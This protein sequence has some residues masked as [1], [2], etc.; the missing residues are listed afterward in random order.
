MFDIF[1]TN[2]LLLPLFVILGIS[3]FTLIFS[4]LLLGTK[5]KIQKK[6]EKEE[7][8]LLQQNMQEFQKYKIT[9]FENIDIKLS[10]SGLKYKFHLNIYMFLIASIVSGIVFG[11]IG[12]RFINDFIFTAFSFAGGLILPYVLLDWIAYFQSAKVKKQV[13]SF[14]AIMINNI[15]IVGDIYNAIIK[16]AQQMENPLKQYLEE[17]ELEYQSGVDLYKCFYR[18]K[19]K[20]AD[21]RFARVIDVLLVHYIKGGKPEVTLSSLQREFIAREV[22]EDRKRKQQFA[23]I[24]GIFIVIGLNVFIVSMMGKFMPEFFNELRNTNYKYYLIVGIINIVISL[25]IATRAI[26][27]KPQKVKK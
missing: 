20:V 5:N 12:K 6:I 8:F 4:V 21:P 24:I 25:Y 23:N 11:F 26:R 9:L 1:K 2:Q 7:N 15:K 16:T 17:F 3:I 27:S 13:M 10:R 19:E 14:V 22:E 18:L